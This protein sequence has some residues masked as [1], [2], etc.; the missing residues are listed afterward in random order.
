MTESEVEDYLNLIQQSSVPGSVKSLHEVQFRTPNTRIKKD[1][2]ELTHT[3]TSRRVH[4]T[5]TSTHTENSESL[6]QCSPW[7]NTAHSLQLQSQ[8]Q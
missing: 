3:H 1:S 4:S 7:G 8:L 2:G 6:S 5:H